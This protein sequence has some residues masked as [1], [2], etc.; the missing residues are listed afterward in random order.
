MTIK[1]VPFARY[2]FTLALLAG[3]IGAFALT[4]ATSA[5]AATA[6]Q[7]DPRPGIVAAPGTHAHPAPDATPGWYSHHG[8]H[9]IAD[10][11][12]KTGR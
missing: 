10:L 11:D 4:L 8:A 7:N 1:T 9:H 12:A 2:L 6:T 3:A 5:H